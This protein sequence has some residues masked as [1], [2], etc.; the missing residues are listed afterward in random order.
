MPTQ[1]TMWLI[2]QFHLQM[3]R[4]LTEHLL[5]LD[6]HQGLNYTN[7]AFGL[8]FMMLMMYVLS[9]RMRLS[10]A[11]CTGSTPGQARRP[12]LQIVGNRLGSGPSKPPSHHKSHIVAEWRCFSRW[13]LQQ[14]WLFL[15]NTLIGVVEAFL[16]Y[17]RLTPLYIIRS[18]A[19]RA[20]YARK[21]I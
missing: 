21:W 20:V 13:Q 2:L 9:F 1:T 14:Q 17:A 19:P 11:A 8:R 10:E 15:T 4:I 3:L 12:A 6:A 16:Y 7:K 5:V 18:K